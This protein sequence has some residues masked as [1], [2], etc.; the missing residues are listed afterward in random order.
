MV[1]DEALAEI[2]GHGAQFLVLLIASVVLWW[3][4]DELMTQRVRDEALETALKRADR[5]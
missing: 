1:N 2:G 4:T 3:I 5:L